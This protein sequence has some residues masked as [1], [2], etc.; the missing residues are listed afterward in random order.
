MGSQRK[1]KGEEQIGKFFCVLAVH[2]QLSNVPVLC[3]KN[4][5]DF[6][7]KKKIKTKPYKTLKQ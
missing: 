5:K 4:I 1:R 6:L 3:F 7:G 2:S